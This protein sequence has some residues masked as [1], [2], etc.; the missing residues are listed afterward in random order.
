MT[1][2]CFLAFSD[3]AE[4]DIAGFRQC[5]GATLPGSL[6]VDE[7]TTS[8]DSIFQ[9]DFE[10][11]PS[12]SDP[13]CIIVSQMPALA[14]DEAKE[15]ALWPSAPQDLAA[16]KS[17][18]IVTTAGSELSLLD[19]AWLMTRVVDAILRSH[20][21]TLGVLWHRHAL[22]I[23]A[24]SYRQ[25]IADLPPDEL[26]LQLWVDISVLPDETPETTALAFTTGMDAFE[27]ME[28]ECVDSPES[29][30]ETYGR[31][32]GACQYLIENGPVLRHGDT[33][34]ETENERIDV[35]HTDSALP[36]E[37]PVIRLR[38]S[39]DE[40]GSLGVPDESSSGLS[41][42]VVLVGI[43]LATILAIFGI[44]KAVGFA[45]AMF[46]GTPP[47][48]PKP[49]VPEQEQRLPGVVNDAAR[50]APAPAPTPNPA[51]RPRQDPQP[52]MVPDPAPSPT[53][54][55]PVVDAPKQASEVNEQAKDV[56]TDVRV[57]RDLA[58]EIILDAEIVGVVRSDGKTM[59]Q[60]TKE[61]GEPDSIP[62]E[63]VSKD[64]QAFAK[65]WYQREQD[66]PTGEDGAKLPIVNDRVKVKWG[67]K[68]WKSR[69]KEVD[70]TRY[71]V[72]YVGWGD[73]WDEW[74][75]ADQLRW[76]DD[77]PVAQTVSLPDPARRA[78]PE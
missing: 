68:W 5:A 26:P 48:K 19:Q 64:D 16:H 49:N 74:K 70:D 31:I 50:S 67:N 39:G 66:R 21:T 28:L 15:S 4:F 59:I 10:S 72:T 34:G 52:T 51:D 54:S 78:T 60:L 2:V 55:Q 36:R 33:L 71:K 41:G 46:A 69:V 6:K 12:D 22:K 77:S 13:G 73:S 32:N 44:V 35:L 18:W 61:D 20:P 63:S 62:Y 65:Q 43:L 29:P 56:W 58:G 9:I 14:I 37:G 1:M 57:W 75:T 17:H 7:I 53:P 3:V 8:S 30:I 25:A 40:D 27:L 38:Y 23:S 47:A 42:I 76:P 45:T 24:E 11:P